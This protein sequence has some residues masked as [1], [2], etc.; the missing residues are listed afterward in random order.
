MA[1]FIEIPPLSK[2]ISRPTGRTDESRMDGRTT[3][4]T[5]PLVTY[6]GRLMLMAKHN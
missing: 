5:V 4:R 6:V 3:R 2:E 1:S